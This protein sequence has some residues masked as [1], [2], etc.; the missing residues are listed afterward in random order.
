MNFLMDKTGAGQETA[1]RAR[2]VADTMNHA[3]LLV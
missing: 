3:V 2:R 1:L